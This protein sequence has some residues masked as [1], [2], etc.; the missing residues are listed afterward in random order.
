MNVIRCRN[1]IVL[2]IS[3]LNRCI[4]SRE[5]HGTQ[6][7][8]FINRIFEKLDEK[9]KR[10]YEESKQE[11]LQR[12]TEIWLEYQKEVAKY[13]QQKRES[14]RHAN[15]IKEAED[16]IKKERQEE[17]VLKELQKR[18]ESGPKDKLDEDYF[19]D[20]SRFDQFN[21]KRDPLFSG[22]QESGS[23]DWRELLK[24]R[25]KE[26][27]E[28]FEKMKESEPLTFHGASTETGRFGY[29]T[30][31]VQNGIIYSI[32]L[33]AA[34]LIADEVRASYYQNKLETEAFLSKD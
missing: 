10:Y 6:S 28:N 30:V 21:D 12:E 25:I 34:I 32:F 4:K 1:S 2:R 11:Y 15:M 31:S 13:S 24:D 20:S 18:F 27:K 16:R 14:Q 8:H 3:P 9:R 23:S 7:V 19:K 26:T 5:F 22:V 29:R 17:A 33:V